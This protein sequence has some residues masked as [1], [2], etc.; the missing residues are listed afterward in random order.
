M[1]LHPNAKNSQERPVISNMSGNSRERRTLKLSEHYFFS[2]TCQE[3]TEV[4]R[5]DIF[6]IKRFISLFEF[7]GE[8]SLHPKQRG[9]IKHSFRVL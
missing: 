3:E 6:N 8:I 1:A 4:E 9:S 2:H 7:S 5:S